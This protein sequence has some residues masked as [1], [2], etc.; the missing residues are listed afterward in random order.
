MKSLNSAKPLCFGF[1]ALCFILFSPR[2]SAQKFDKV[3]GAGM[4][5]KIYTGDVNGYNLLAYTPDGP[6]S[7]RLNTSGDELS[8]QVITQALEKQ[9]PVA[10]GVFA[11]GSDD[12][13]I[14]LRKT[15]HQDEVIFD[16]TLVAPLQD[17]HVLDIFQTLDLGYAITGYMLEEKNFFYQGTTFS[18]L[19][20]RAFL[21]KID[22]NGNQEFLKTYNEASDAHDN[23]EGNKIIQRPDGT[24]VMALSTLGYG[25]SPS[26]ESESAKIWI[27]AANGNVMQ[28]INTPLVSHY[29]NQAEI[30]SL[31]NT[32]DGGFLAAGIYGFIATRC[33]PYRSHILKYNYNGE[34]VWDN[35][36]I[37]PTTFPQLP[38]NIIYGALENNRGEYMILGLTP[39]DFCNQG[40]GNP[41]TM[42]LYN[43]QGENIANT[44]AAP[45]VVN[46]TNPDANL[47][48]ID[49]QTTKDD[50][51]I[52]T[53]A[54]NG[55]IHVFKFGNEVFQNNQ[56]DLELAIRTNNNQPA[57]YTN[58]T[59][60]FELKNNGTADA[61]N[62]I[63][64]LPLPQHLVYVGGNEASVTSGTFVPYGI[65]Q[66]SLPVLR[67]GEKHYLRVNYFNLTNQSKFVYGQVVYQTEPDFDSTPGG[68]QCCSPVEDDEAALE[69]NP[70]VQAKPDLTWEQ[71]NFLP[72]V[73]G[74]GAS[75]N[76]DVL[77][78][79]IGNASAGN[80][81]IETWLSE[82][83]HLDVNSD[84]KLYDRT[85]FGLAPDAG[86]TT[87]FAVHEIPNNIPIGSYH[88][89]F[90]TD[91]SDA[92]PEM[93]EINNIFVSP[94]E[95]IGQGFPDL[96]PT[97]NLNINSNLSA[98]DLITPEV[99]YSNLGTGVAN[100]PFNIALYLSTDSNLDASDQLLKQ[101]TLVFPFIIHT[102]YSRL[103]QP[104]AIPTIT[105]TG[106]Y[107][108]ITKMDSDDELV[109]IDETNNFFSY[110]VH[111]EGVPQ[112][113]VDLELG[114][115]GPTNNPPNFSYFTTV[116]KIE[117]KGTAT[118]SNIVILMPHVEGAVYQGGNEYYA[119]KGTYE[120]YG[121]QSWR[122]SSLAAGE[123][124]T[125]TMNF[126][127]LSPQI[128]YQ[129]GFVVSA[130]GQDIDSNPGYVNCCT[131]L[132]DDEA[133][134]ELAPNYSTQLANRNI[135]FENMESEITLLERA[136]P[137]P[138]QDYTTL[139]ILSKEAIT[140]PLII[141]DALGRIKKEMEVSLEKGP[142]QIP[143]DLSQWPSGTYQVML[144]PFHPYLRK[145][146]FLK[147]E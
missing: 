41:N 71:V 86:G 134:F 101:E 30:K 58:F 88:L 63:V 69:I 65:D 115:L 92:I 1:L 55:E 32:T 48:G 144:Y 120:L 52:L 17:I 23:A 56:P 143:I 76:A 78:K 87:S 59:I 50:N 72:S 44:A 9:I 27:I 114:I 126:F 116:A 53:A 105:Q 11:A 102:A 79:N 68:W 38:G 90:V 112:A 40:F 66:W 117:N 139:L 57:I 129:F 28:E 142:N 16:K 110:P 145:G 60:E 20:K 5:A 36:N 67:A 26:V 113:G 37:A 7:I 109:E 138:A 29:F 47:E 121:N 43:N 136:D 84:I 81:T 103:F 75:F 122:I 95:I 2:L 96:K 15:N 12:F 35:R 91:A 104:F 62:I 18:I 4:G 74:L 51:Y 19:S 100:P 3:Y 135:A 13:I 70:G 77:F 82:D 25:S 39:P 83:D 97:N 85:I 127:R 94:I 10:E 80:F 123:A 73:V 111:I 46:W 33:Y 64:Q 140:T 137:N 99:V 14:R 131:P 119:S 8:R 133:Y 141:Y 24:F 132:E 124:A 147:V 6:V 49:I 108:I 61:H 45:L 22:A 31:I 130:D 146:R 106:N 118:A 128:V 34:L 89:I 107:F 98:G 125:L 54:K 21:L 42:H 93:D